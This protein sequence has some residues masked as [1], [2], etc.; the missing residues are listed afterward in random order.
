M[1]PQLPDQ[2]QRKLTIWCAQHDEK[3]LEPCWGRS[4]EPPSLTSSESAGILR[5]LMS[6]DNPTPEIKEAVHAGVRWF[7][8]SQIQ[9]IKQIHVNGDKMIV[10]AKDAAATLG[11]VLRNRRQPP[12][13]LWPRR[14]DQVRHRENRAGAPQRLCLVR[15]L[16]QGRRLPVW[17]LERA[18]ESTTHSG[19][20]RQKWLKPSGS[21]PR[22]PAR[23]RRSPDL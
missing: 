19:S 8:D 13:F 14:R 15:Y 20:M 11:T 23:D 4:F 3:T 9:G 21:W 10:S 6:Q 2:S 22:L 16:G 1:H 5:L 7:A 17:P 12:D 18:M